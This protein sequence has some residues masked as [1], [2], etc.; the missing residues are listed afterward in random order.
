M[1]FLAQIVA[2]INVPANALGKLFLAPIG[3]LPGWLSNTII[4]AVAG[5]IFLVIFKYTSNQSARGRIWDKIKAN[6]LAQRLFKDS[7]V[8]TLQALGRIFKCAFFLLVGAVR[9]L[10]VM[11]V[12]VCLLLSQ[13]GLWYEFRPLRP[14]EEALVTMK[15]NGES[16][17]PW[18]NV[19]IEPKPET[20]ITIGPVRVLSKREIYWKI[21][22]VKNGFSS[23]VF[24]IDNQQIEKELVIGDGFMRISPERPGWQWADILLYPWEKPFGP[25]STVQSITIDYPKRIS[26]TS[27]SFWWIIYFFVISVMFALIFMPVLKVRM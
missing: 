2:W 11:I 5:V 23:I 8:V 19:S 4:S 27:G 6:M 16:D 12:P 20:E 18:P 3:M 15:I 1:N 7:L 25:D 22:A 21:K 9:P 13:M 24:N 14:G 17:S 26:I 10:L